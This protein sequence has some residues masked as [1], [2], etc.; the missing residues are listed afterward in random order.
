LDRDPNGR[1][2]LFSDLVQKRSFGIIFLFLCIALWN[3]ARICYVIAKSPVTIWSCLT[4]HSIKV[5]KF[6]AELHFILGVDSVMQGALPR[7]KI[8][9]SRKTA[10]LSI[11]DLRT[12][13]QRRHPSPRVHRTF[14]I[15]RSSVVLDSVAVTQQSK[16]HWTKKWA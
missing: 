14:V 9:E 12:S 13:Q 2:L 3:F 4:L 11:A 10:R 6:V 5:S 16:S 8:V 15:K 1:H 7:S